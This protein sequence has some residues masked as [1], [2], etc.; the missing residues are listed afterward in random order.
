MLYH[1]RM[2]L[3]SHMTRWLKHLIKFAVSRIWIFVGHSKKLWLHWI[4]T[5]LQQYKLPPFQ[6][7]WRVVTYVPVL[8]LELVCLLLCNCSFIYGFILYFNMH[9]CVV[10]LLIAFHYLY[11]FKFCKIQYKWPCYFSVSFLLI[12]HHYIFIKL[13]PWEEH[14][15]VIG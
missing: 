10:D 8:P 4:T 1:C 9:L 15:T 5:G 6:K 13:F 14:L 11:C 2:S 3:K 12:F 7:H